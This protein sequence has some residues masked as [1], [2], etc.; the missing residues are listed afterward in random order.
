MLSGQFPVRG[1][2]LIIADRTGE[3]SG[4]PRPAVLLQTR[5]L[6]KRFRCRF[7]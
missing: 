2:V 1:D 3:F 7:I 5:S 6:A 4:K